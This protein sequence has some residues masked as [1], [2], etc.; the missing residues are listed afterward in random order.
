MKLSK[1]VSSFRFQVSSSSG[2][3]P[4][5]LN[6]KPETKPS[7]PHLFIF[8]AVI[9]T[10]CAVGPNYRK[11][12][13]AA[14][15]AWTG[16]QVSAENAL[17]QEARPQ[18]AAARGAWWTIFN[19]PIL[20]KIETQVVE[21]NQTVEAALARLKRARAE[22]RLPAADL[23]PRVDLNPSFTNFQRSLGSFGGAGSIK[24]GRAN[25]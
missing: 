2:N 17:W 3:R 22:A 16:A 4:E 13:M 23:L 18:D 5:T 12:A 9:V 10:G 25:V 19:D 14:P 6:L 1:S 21:A 7:V 24:I 11:P 15:A 20:N 8:M